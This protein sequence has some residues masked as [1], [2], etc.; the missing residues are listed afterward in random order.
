MTTVNVVNATRR[1]RYYSYD[2]FE[3]VLAPVVQRFYGEVIVASFANVAN[4]LQSRFAT[5]LERKSHPLK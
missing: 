5:D 4:A 3:G 2:R 1:C